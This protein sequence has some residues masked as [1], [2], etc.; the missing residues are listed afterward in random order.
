MTLHDRARKLAE[1]KRIYCDLCIDDG[2]CDEGGPFCRRCVATMATVDELA[3]MLEDFARD[4]ARESVHEYVKITGVL[5]HR[6]A[7]DKAC[8]CASCTKRYEAAIA[9]AEKGSTDDK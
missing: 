4:F 5:S 8:Q 9:A 6:G 1:R 2:N 3:T 7:P